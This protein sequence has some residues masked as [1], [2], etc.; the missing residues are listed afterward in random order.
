MPDRV[1]RAESILEY[2]TVKNPKVKSD[3]KP[4]TRQSSQLWWKFPTYVE[5]WDE[6]NFETMEKVFGGMLMRECRDEKNKF[7]FLEP[8]L[9]PEAQDQDTSEPAATAILNLWTNTVVNKALIAVKDTLHPVY[10]AQQRNS[11]SV[12]P[13]KESVTPKQVQRGN[14][15]PKTR[16]AVAGMPLSQIRRGTVITDASGLPFSASKDSGSNGKPLPKPFNRLPKEIKSG[17]TW[18]SSKA[19]GRP[20]G[21][22]SS[23]ITKNTAAPVRQIYQQCIQARSRYGCI[24]TTQEAFLVRIGPYRGSSARVKRTKAP[25]TQDQLYQ[26]V[27]DE[28]LLEYISIPWAVHRKDNDSLEKFRTMTMNLAIWFQHILAGHNHELSWR[29][30]PLVDENFRNDDKKLDEKNPKAT[31]VRRDSHK[32]LVVEIPTMSSFASLAHSDMDSQETIP[33]LD[34]PETMSYLQTSFATEGDLGEPSSIGRRQKRKYLPLDA[35]ET[36]S[37]PKRRNRGRLPKG[38]IQSQ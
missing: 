15:T 25:L 31:H 5:P 30:K 2:L 19:I 22:T 24:I 17:S 3:Y 7:Y 37:S 6:F 29:Y 21:E 34:G 16:L 10:W 20:R 32:E 12:K 1:R 14:N 23:W 33:P 18:V 36:S 38:A 8:Q 27:T 26:A 35:E 11:A 28:G 9:V 4:H 13:G